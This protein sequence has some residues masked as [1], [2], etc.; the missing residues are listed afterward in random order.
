RVYKI[1]T[2]E[3]PAPFGGSG[4]D[5]EGAWRIQVDTRFARQFR[6][7]HEIEDLVARQD[8][9]RAE[10]GRQAAAFVAKYSAARTRGRRLQI[11]SQP[12]VPSD[13]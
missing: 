5:A 6:D 8:S 4:V 3:H 13:Y 12:K 1:L 9:V 10:T 2:R 11:S 7:L